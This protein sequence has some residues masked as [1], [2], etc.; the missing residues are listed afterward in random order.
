MK[1]RVFAVLAVPALALGFALATPGTEQAQAYPFPSVTDICA[2]YDW[3]I[4]ESVAW[5]DEVTARAWVDQAEAFGC[6][7]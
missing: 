1:R 7:V 5:G 2:M 3:K 6:E 4:A